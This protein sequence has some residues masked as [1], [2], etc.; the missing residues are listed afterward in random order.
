VT[1]VETKVAGE[2]AH[3]FAAITGFPP[4][5]Y[6]NSAN[7][8]LVLPDNPYVVARDLALNREHDG[9]VVVTEPYFM[10]QPETLAR[11]LAGDYDGERLVAGKLRPSIF[12]EYARCV[13]E[14]LVAAYSRSK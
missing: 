12:H 8:V 5:L 13:A 3:R 2:I 4:V 7:T 1:P 11:L 10:N 14:G 6:G 9:P